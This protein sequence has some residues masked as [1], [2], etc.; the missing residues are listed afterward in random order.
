MPSKVTKGT[1]SVDGLLKAM[2]LLSR[3]V[4]YVLEARA[5]EE[6]SG[7][8]LSSSKVQIFRLLGLKGSQTSS[9]VARFLGV[10]KPAVSQIVDTMVRDK[11]VSRRPATEDR[12]EVNLCLTA[13]G[14]RIYQAL[15]RAQRNF[16]KGALKAAR[17]ASPG[18][19]TKALLEITNGLAEADKDFKD[20][21][22]QC[23][24]NDDDSCVLAGGDSECCYLEHQ[25]ATTRRAKLRQTRSRY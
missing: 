21:C 2:L 4:E 8:A 14:T 1:K 15:Q 7:L 11:H 3:T 24:A 13:K 18:K 19:W 25:A 22:L 12:R 16:I 17:V 6:A 23:S 10:S 9:Q 20:Y 5:V